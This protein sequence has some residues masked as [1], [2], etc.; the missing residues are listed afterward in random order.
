MV[1]E[2]NILFYFSDKCLYLLRRVLAVFS[3]SLF[4]C[5]TD[6]KETVP[7]YQC[8]CNMQ[9]VQMMHVNNMVQA[10]K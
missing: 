4:F 9:I 3:L 2:V 1:L 7:F 6:L 8:L 10:F 5:T